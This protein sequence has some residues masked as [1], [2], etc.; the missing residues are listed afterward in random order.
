MMTSFVMGI[1]PGQSGAIALIDDGIG[2][3]EAVYDMPVDECGLWRIAREIEKEGFVRRI[4]LEKVGPMP[5][6]GIS[7][8]FKFGQNY[9][10]L[11]AWAAKFEVP[12]L[13]VTP[14]KWQNAILDSDRGSDPKKRSLLFAR[15]YWPAAPLH[16]EKHHGRADALCLAE[17]ARRQG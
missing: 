12:F 15:R 5:K 8:T 14:Q 10:M 4:C 7:S 11:R 1:D 17:Y 9:G 13:L 3:Y 6:Q 16:L 2:H